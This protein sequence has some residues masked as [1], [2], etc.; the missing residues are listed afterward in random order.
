MRMGAT[1]PLA[2]RAYT[3]IVSLSFV[4]ASSLFPVSS[5]RPVGLLNPV[6]A[7]AI[8]RIGAVLPVAV[9]G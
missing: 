6:D 5:V 1:L 2:V 4:T 7:P 8:V 3:V 9:R